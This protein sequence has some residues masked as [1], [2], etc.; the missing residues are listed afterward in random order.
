MEKN[1]KIYVAGHRGMVGSAIVRELE[2]QGYTNIIT[3]THR[4]LDLLR[5]EEVPVEEIVE[6]PTEMVE[7]TTTEETWF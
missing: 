6:E 3:R 7:D 4:E 2:R 5:Q 1:S